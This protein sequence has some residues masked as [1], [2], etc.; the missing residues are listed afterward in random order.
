MKRKLIVSLF[1]LLLIQSVVYAEALHYGAGFSTDGNRNYLTD[2]TYRESFSWDAY[3]SSDFGDFYSI[4]F[5]AYLYG[6]LDALSLGSFKSQVYLGIGAMVHRDDENMFSDDRNENDEYYLYQIAR[7]PLGI[8]YKFKGSGLS[9]S[10]DVAFLYLGN[11]EENENNEEE[12]DR[13][14][15]QTSVSI[16]YYFY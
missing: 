16:K 13:V 2:R 10:I 4:Y 9:F 1:A 5:N 15:T 7:L 14:T 11:P 3:I 6:E 12:E 8:E